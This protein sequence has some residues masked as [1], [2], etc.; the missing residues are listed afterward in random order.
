M[1]EKKTDVLIV[2]DEADIR[3]LIQGILEDEGYHSRTAATSEEAYEQINLHVPHLII[4]DIWLQHSQDDGIDILAK[5]KEKYPHIPVIMISGHGTIETAV[6]TIKNGA[7]DF[8]EKPFKT[9]RLILMVKRALEAAE[10]RRENAVLKEITKKKMEMSLNGESQA[11]QSVRQ[12][13]ERVGAT[14]SRVLITGEPGT[15]KEMAARLLHKQ[16]ARSEGP[17]LVINCAMMHPERIEE[18]LF[19]VDAGE[20]HLS[21]VGMLER[22]NGGTLLFDEISDMPYETQGKIVRI[23][24]EQ[25]FR[26]IGGANP[27]KVDVRF[28]AAT[29]RDLDEMIAQQ[30]FRKDLYYRLNVVPLEMPRLRD[31]IQDIPELVHVFSEELAVES[32]MPYKEFDESVIEI[33]KSYSWPGNIRQLKNAIEW[34]MIM[35]GPSCKVIESQFLPPDLSSSSDASDSSGASSR[36]DAAAYQRMSPDI[37]SLSLREA[38]EE[39]ER[40]YLLSQIQRFEGNVSKTAKFVGMERSALHRKLKMLQVVNKASVEEESESSSLQ[41]KAV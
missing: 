41:R 29:H 4:L 14:N 27:I 9:D 19:G 2:D 40:Q 23:I 38:R 28:L 12:L 35:S 39:F 7:Y 21:S 37:L 13:V 6:S 10:L 18:E 22:A 1:N 20:D 24:Q 25:T 36:D 8:I 5:V 16:S 15:G 30:K 17:F 31:R 34:M 3:N 11:I 32:G 26:R 33:M